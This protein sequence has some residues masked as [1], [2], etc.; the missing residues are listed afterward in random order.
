MRRQKLARNAAAKSQ[1]TTVGFHMMKAVL[2]MRSVR[3]PNTSTNPAETRWS[4][5][6]RR[7][8]SQ[9]IDT[10]STVA[11]MITTVAT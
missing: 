7:V 5:F 11:T 2:C 9:W 10:C 3:L 6:T 1:L 8:R 4:G